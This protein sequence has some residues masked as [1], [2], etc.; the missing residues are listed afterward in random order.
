MRSLGQIL[1][2]G[3]RAVPR[4]RE[5]VVSVHFPKAAGTSLRTQLA[6]LLG[7]RMVL[8]YAQDPVGA[9]RIESAPFP[10]GALL[11]HGHFNARR[12][13]DVTA[14]RVTFLRHPVDNL[15]SI[16]VFW[17]AAPATDHGVHARFL[18]ERPSILEFAAHYTPLARLMSETYF[19][20][21]DMARFE[22]VGFHETRHTDI[23]ALGTMLG[24]PLSAEVAE[25]RTP[26]RP[27][28]Q[29]IEADAATRARLTDLLAQD[30][31]FYDREWRRWKG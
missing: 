22:F 20:G 6:R 16:Y 7:D 8:D 31:A 11:V 2:E 28:R 29:A 30:V 3:E 21:V 17:L 4:P 9:D 19:G 12:Y 27:E 1:A 15:I 23:P 14:R 24:L 10:P 5:R 13:A 25:N 18:R 26:T